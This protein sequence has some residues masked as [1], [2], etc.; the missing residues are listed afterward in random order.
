MDYIYIK[1]EGDSESLKETVLKLKEFTNVELIAS[2]NTEVECGITGVH[3]Q[4]LYL[5]AMGHVFFKRFGKSPIRME[6][7]IL[8]LGKKVMSSGDTYECFE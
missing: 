4:A 7:N 1:R 8:E 6:N 2:Y 5:M 3:S